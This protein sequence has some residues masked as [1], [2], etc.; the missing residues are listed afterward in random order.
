MR[1]VSRSELMALPPGTLYHEWEPCYFHSLCIKGKT[2]PAEEGYRGDW[3]QH[4]VPQLID[5]K[6]PDNLQV[7]INL[8]NGASIPLTFNLAGREALCDNTLRYAVWERSDV[9][10]FRDSL[11]RILSEHP[12]SSCPTCGA[13]G[14]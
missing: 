1:I 3:W 8:D 6:E 5:E 4:V 7:L 2:I 10:A 13:K 11:D 14:R 12:E 9:E